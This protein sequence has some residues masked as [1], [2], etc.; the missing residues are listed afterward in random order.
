MSFDA[1][2]TFIILEQRASDF[3]ALLGLAL[4]IPRLYRIIENFKFSAKHGEFELD[5]FVPQLHLGFEYQ[6]EQHFKDVFHAAR[7]ARQQD[8][9][10][11]KAAACSEVGITLI[12]IPYDWEGDLA[13]LELVITTQP[14]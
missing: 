1:I 10:S 5:L 8:T 14:T 13:S 2:S 3:P 6:G 11:N 12:E 4:I 7:V 9:D